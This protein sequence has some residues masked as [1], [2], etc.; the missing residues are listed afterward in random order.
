MAKLIELTDSGLVY[1][2][3]NQIYQM[4]IDKMLE[5]DPNWN[6]DPSTPDGYMAAWMAEK[7][8]EAV[9]AVVIA[10]NSKDR[11]KARDTQLN[12]IG[13]LTG[14]FREDG[15]PSV[16]NITCSGT[17]GA[18][19]LAGSVIEGEQSW[20]IDSNVTIQPGGTVTATATCAIVGPVDPTVGSVNTI[21]TTIGGWAS[22]T[23]TSTA[24]IG[25]NQQSNASFRTE[26]AKAV[27]RP[28][29]NQVD[30]TIGEIFAIDDVLRVVGYEN[31]TGAS[32]V[33]PENPHG[34][35]ANSC[36]YL[37]QGGDD[38][39][40]A[41]AIYIKKNP[42]VLLNQEGTPI[43]VTV[44]SDVHPSN[45]KIIK[46]GRPTAVN[47]TVAID[48]ID[49]L[50]NLPVNIEELVQDA[51]IKYI[52]GELIDLDD[53]FDPSGFDIGE[54]VPVR[55]IDTPINHVIGQ[56]KG[57]YINSLTINT[58]TSGA[59]PIAFDSISTW[60]PSNITVTVS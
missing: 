39:A 43:E 22:V 7:W 58:L 30:N 32:S 4:I 52:N 28:G 9:E 60:L 33:S 12:A 55:R 6:L 46:F 8:R 20:T 34:L 17:P 35:P 37:V 10:Y 18:V 40:I 27:S 13:A 59:V 53:G 50:G 44:T 21:K 11:A 16:I 45:N 31:P 26:Q 36:T 19:I 51:I 29:S 3:E 24:T 2:T 5:I 48:L 25:T 1:M 56:Y 54:D 41:K 14:S 57:S 47:M 15:T 49:P 38:A 42:G 23:N